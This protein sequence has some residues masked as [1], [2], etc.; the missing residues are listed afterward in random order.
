[1][2]DFPTSEE[3]SCAPQITGHFDQR[4]GEAQARA[5]VRAYNRATGPQHDAAPGEARMS[6]RSGWDGFDECVDEDQQDLARSDRISMLERLDT[7]GRVAP[8]ESESWTDEEIHQYFS[9]GKSRL[10]MSSVCAVVCAACYGHCSR[11]S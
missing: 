9:P 7:Y 8:P 6:S 10:R 3:T 1:M 4:D 11:L 5:C 2:M